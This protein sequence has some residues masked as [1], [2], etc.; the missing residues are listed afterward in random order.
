VCLTFDLSVNVLAQWSFSKALAMA[1]CNVQPH[2]A[3]CHVGGICECG[4]DDADIRPSMQYVHTLRYMVRHKTVMYNWGLSPKLRCRCAPK[5]NPLVGH[6][7]YRQRH[8]PM[9]H[10]K[11]ADAL[12]STVSPCC[13]SQAAEPPTQRVTSVCC[14]RLNV[15][16][17]DT[18]R[19]TT[20]QQ[21]DVVP[22]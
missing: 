15:Q 5:A 18:N 11:L 20:L 4:G 14:T 6:T 1:L 16:K 10:L 12:E 21:P 3:L 13:Y 22:E 17:A 7:E 8:P 19:P 2:W 9:L